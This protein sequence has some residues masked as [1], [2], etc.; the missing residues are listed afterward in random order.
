MDEAKAMI[1]V[2]ALNKMMTGRHFSICVI[3]DVAA[4]LGVDPKGESYRMLRPLH[5]VNW[6]D[7]PSELRAMVPGLIKDCLGVEPAYRFRVA[8]IAIVPE[9]A[10]TSDSPR[11]RRLLRLLGR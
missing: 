2:T 4:M 11:P 8:E 5:C 9:S 3:T 10:P 7:M 6:A 1:A